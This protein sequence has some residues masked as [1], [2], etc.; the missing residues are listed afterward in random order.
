MRMAGR[1]ALHDLLKIAQEVYESILEA[2]SS[3]RKY[4]IMEVTQA[5]AETKP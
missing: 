4:L 5:F 3:N 1:V 2:L